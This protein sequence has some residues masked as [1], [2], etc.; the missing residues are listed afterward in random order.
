MKDDIMIHIR[1]LQT[2]F[3]EHFPPKTENCDWIPSPFN[4]TVPDLR[5]K[6][7]EQCIELTFNRTAPDFRSEDMEQCIGLTFNRTVPDFRSKDMEQ[8]IELTFTKT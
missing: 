3:N 4:R 2:T 7:M 6:D 8:W 5:S 1:G